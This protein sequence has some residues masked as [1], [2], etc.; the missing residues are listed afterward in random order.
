MTHLAEAQLGQNKDTA[1]T[2]VLRLDGFLVF[3]FGFVIGMEGWMD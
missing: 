2:R 3:W 1:F